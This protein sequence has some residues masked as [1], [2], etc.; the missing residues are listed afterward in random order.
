M[1]EHIEQTW[2]FTLL[3]S[4]LEVCGWFSILKASA[5]YLLGESSKIVV[6]SVYCCFLTSNNLSDKEVSAMW[7][8]QYGNVAS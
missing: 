3:E 8:H 7:M 1:R 6:F 5:I 2:Y 4:F